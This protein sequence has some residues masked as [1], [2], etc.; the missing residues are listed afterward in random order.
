MKKNIL[1][2]YNAMQYS[3]FFPVFYHV[4]TE[5]SVVCNDFTLNLKKE[6]YC[7]KVDR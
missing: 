1:L 7:K 6:F 5:N 4:M 2:S 3:Y